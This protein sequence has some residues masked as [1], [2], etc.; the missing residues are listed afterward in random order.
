LLD[1][2]DKWKMQGRDSAS[3]CFGPL[4]GSPKAIPL[5]A[6][7]ILTCKALILKDLFYAF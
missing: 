5:S 2:A 6:E 3:T 4:Q 1:K 7:K